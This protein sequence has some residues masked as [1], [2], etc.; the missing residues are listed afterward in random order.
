MSE[1]KRDSDARVSPLNF[2]D[3]LRNLL[4][5]EHPRWLNL[6]KWLVAN[7]SSQKHLEKITRKKCVVEQDPQ[8]QLKKTWFHRWFFVRFLKFVTIAFPKIT[9]NAGFLTFTNK[10]HYEILS[11]SKDSPISLLKQLFVATRQLRSTSIS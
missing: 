1:L 2:V 11:S 5:V 10:Y 3:F 4:F 8:V 6:Q 7:V 9:W